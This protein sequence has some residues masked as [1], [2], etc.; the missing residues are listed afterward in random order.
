MNKLLHSIRIRAGWLWD[1]ALQ[2]LPLKAAIRLEFYRYH[3]RLPRL[4]P[5]VTFCEKIMH[6]KIVDRDPRLPRLQDKILVKEYVAEILGSEW[7]IP[8]LWTGKELPRRT[9]RNWPIPFVIKA[10]HGCGWNYFVRSE[11]ELDW[12]RIES[13]TRQW[14]RTTFGQKLHEWL[15]SEI[16]P[17]LLVEP[18]VGSGEAAPPDYKFHVFNGR[19]VFIQV[20]LGRLQAHRQLFYDPGW[21]RLPY[22]YVC[23]FDGGDVEPPQSYA[24]MLRAAERLGKDF[25]YVRIDLYEINGKP[26]FGEFTFYPNSGIISFKPETIEYE[27]GR[28]W[29]DWPAALPSATFR[30]S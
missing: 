24:E 8:N 3:R 20:D 25:P 2:I 10:N 9:E 29:P 30:R 19:T 27:L 11:K 26:M 15:Y 14:L 18:F 4:N 21:K 13:L 12:D 7:V 22:S 16:Q 17:A 23:P 1:V 28:L 6:R 5:P